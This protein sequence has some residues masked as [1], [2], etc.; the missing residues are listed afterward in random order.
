M[1]LDAIKNFSR[2]IAPYFAL[3]RKPLAVKDK[4]KLN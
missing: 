2:R 4:I 3:W 1:F